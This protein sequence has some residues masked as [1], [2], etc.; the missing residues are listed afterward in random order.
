L[1]AN[2]NL[3]LKLF[4]GYETFNYAQDLKDHSFGGAIGYDKA[5]NLT[6]RVGGL[7]S[8]GITNYSTDNISGDSHDW[9]VG[10]YVDHKNGNWDYQG[11][12]TYGHNKY[13]LDRYVMSDKLNS[14]Y[15][16]KVW[17]VEAKAKY[18]IPSTAAK[19]GSSPRT[20]K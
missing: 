1:D 15:K 3:W 12:V 11:L 20:A 5:L 2:N 4:K 6:T 14:D 9:R 10:A 18:L 19:P 16:A 7:F 13:D 8:Y 17:D